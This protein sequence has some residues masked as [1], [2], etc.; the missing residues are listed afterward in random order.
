[1]KFALLLLVVLTASG[2]VSEPSLGIMRTRG[3][4][5]RELKGF[6]GSIVPGATLADSAS[7][8]ASCGIRV[9]IRDEAGLRFAGGETHAAP[10]GPLTAGFDRDCATAFLYFP[11]TRQ[12]SAMRESGWEELPIDAGAL[13]G[14]VVALTGALTVWV[15]RGDELFRV[16]IRLGEA[17]WNPMRQ[18]EF[19]RNSRS[20]RLKAASCTRAKRPS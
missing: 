1:M 17:R 11:Q 12:F 15:R 9:L 4:A 10:G 6:A 7:A 18:P 14:E 3:G 8:S 5:V 20:G 2:A 19:I 13:H 16:R